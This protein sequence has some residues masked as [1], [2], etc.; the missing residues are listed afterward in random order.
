VPA[1]LL[2]LV[3]VE[4]DLVEREADGSW[5]VHVTIAAQDQWR[6]CCP[7]CGQVLGRVKDRTAHTLTH[8]V[9]APMPL[10]WH[11]SRFRCENSICDTASFTEAGP[12]AGARAG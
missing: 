12:V 5:R 1:Q 4:V 9:L 3:G 11:K 2:G 7:G 8:V 10:T 6:A